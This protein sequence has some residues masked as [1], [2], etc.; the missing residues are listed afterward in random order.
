MCSTLP[1]IVMIYLVYVRNFFC[2][3][4]GL[5]SCCPLVQDSGRESI[6]LE[7][8]STGVVVL[9]GLGRGHYSCVLIES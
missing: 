4:G 3:D 9:S 6:N 7:F 1:L 2:E 8:F 5:R